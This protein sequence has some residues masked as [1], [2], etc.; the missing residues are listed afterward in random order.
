MAGAAPSSTV[1]WPLAV[2]CLYAALI[3]FQP[4]LTFGD[5]SPLRFAAAD[6]VAP[7]VFLAALLHPRRQIPFALAA[8]A[9]AIPLLAATST[10]LSWAD[11]P[12]SFYA[13][14]KTAGLFYLVGV[15]L[16]MVRCTEKGDGQRILRALAFGAFW[17]AGL[18][19]AGYAAYL[20]GIPNSLVESDRLCGTLPG[21]PNSYGGLVAIGLLVTAADRGLRPTTRLV[22]CTVLVLALLASG[23]RSAVAGA[24][25]G[26]VALTVVR[27]RDPFVTGLR[28]AF[29]LLLGS[30]A[31]TGV[32]V[33][34]VGSGAAERVWSHYWRDKTVASRMDLYERAL[35]LFTENPITGL[36]IGGFREMNSFELGGR[37][38]SFVVHN[39]YL[40]AFVDLGIAGGFLLIGLLAG[41]IWHS[42][43]SARG[44]P[45]IETGAVVAACL[46]SMAVFNL[47]IDGF[48]QRHFWVLVA[49]A[50][51][52][53]V[54][55]AARR[56]QRVGAYAGT[57][58]ASA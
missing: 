15:A 16:A 39:V 9:G 2:V 31:L 18:G 40:W 55:R 19:V 7:L 34:S 5:G 10:L 25:A 29:T 8:V 22:R 17:S 56:P 42:V 1:R 24:I 47:F 50:I 32:L 58:R 43:R 44:R 14:G 28:T 20:G 26:A 30:M 3:P 4:V 45:G 52:L 48:F 6:A 27:A 21:D 36:G 13:I 57:A 11:R 35:Q 51:A 33:T 37:M 46:V 38:G 12:I 41:G 23:S 49:C 53:P 54:Y